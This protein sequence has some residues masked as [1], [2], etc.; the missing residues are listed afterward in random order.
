MKRNWWVRIA[1]VRD[2][3]KRV[4]VSLS[5]KLFDMFYRGLSLYKDLDFMNP[6]ADKS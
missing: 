1:F 3:R 4:S 5:L 2:E 6:Y